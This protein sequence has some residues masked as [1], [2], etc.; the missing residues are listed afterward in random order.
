MKNVEN[1]TTQN[2]FA[3]RAIFDRKGFNLPF[4]FIKNEKHLSENDFKLKMNKLKSFRTVLQSDLPMF[5]DSRQ[6]FMEI[7]DKF[8]N[9][10]MN[11]SLK[12]TGNRVTFQQD[13]NNK[14]PKK[15]PTPNKPKA[16]NKSYNER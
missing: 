13:L 2:Y 16:S 6:V 8:A 1:L 5:S 3:F 15:M 10:L 14:K 12:S 4:I 9:Q 11:S 7:C